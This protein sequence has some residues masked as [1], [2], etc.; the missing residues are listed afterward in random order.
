MSPAHEVIRRRIAEIDGELAA[1]QRKRARLIEL[2]RELAEL[3]AAL[4]VMERSELEAEAEEV[5]HG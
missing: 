1:M 3:E 4:T 2:R 5:S